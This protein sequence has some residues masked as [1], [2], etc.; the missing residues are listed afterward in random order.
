MKHLKSKA[1]YQ[2]W[3]WGLI[4]ELAV[5]FQKHDNTR[6]KNFTSSDLDVVVLSVKRRKYE[7]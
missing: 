1:D 4:Q 7:D 5:S 3:L 6:V 2:D